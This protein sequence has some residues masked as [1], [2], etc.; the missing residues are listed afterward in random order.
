[1]IQLKPQKR[2]EEIALLDFRFIIST[3]SSLI[4]QPHLHVKR[5]GNS[6]IIH[7]PYQSTLNDRQM[8]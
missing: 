8:I 6:A 2:E 4:P 1:M 5:M 7:F 3:F